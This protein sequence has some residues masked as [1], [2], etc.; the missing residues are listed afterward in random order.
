MRKVLPAPGTT[1]HNGRG[2]RA[3]TRWC[4]F[5]GTII[6]QDKLADRNWL[7][8]FQSC[9]DS[10]CNVVRIWSERA[11]VGEGG[12]MPWPDTEGGAGRESLE[13]QRAA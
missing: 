7:A 12:T 4:K 10:S 1:E 3:V 9:K 5:G 13:A 6:A 11:L 8:S 2:G